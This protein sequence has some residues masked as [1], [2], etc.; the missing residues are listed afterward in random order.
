MIWLPRSDSERREV[1]LLLKGGKI[2]FGLYINIFV[3]GLKA[4]HELLKRRKNS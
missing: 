1:V 3:V 4:L 2:K